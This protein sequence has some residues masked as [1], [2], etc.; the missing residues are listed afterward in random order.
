M[1]TVVP[2]LAVLIELIIWS[3][4]CCLL[5]DLTPIGSEFVGIGLRHFRSQ[6]EDE[7]AVEHKCPSCLSPQARRTSAECRT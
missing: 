2:D 5:R 7:A 6:A 4:I 1:L 3:A